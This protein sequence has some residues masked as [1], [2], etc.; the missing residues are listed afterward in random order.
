MR[1][2]LKILLLMT[3]YCFISGSGAYEMGAISVLSSVNEPLEAR[4][5]LSGEEVL[6]DG[7]VIVDMASK[8]D[9]MRHKVRRGYFVSDLK[10]SFEKD[11]LGEPTIRIQSSQPVM[12]RGMELLVM[13][14]TTQEK[15]LGKYRFVLPQVRAVNDPPIVAENR[16]PNERQKRQALAW[17]TDSVEQK[18][19]KRIVSVD[20]K[21]S[22]DRAHNSYTVL[23]GDSLSYIAMK[24]I[25]NYPQFRSWKALM[26]RIAEINSDAFPDRDINRLRVAT[27][28]KLPA[29]H[30]DIR[31]S[32]VAV[33]SLT[34]NSFVS[35]VDRHTTLSKAPEYTADPGSTKVL[36]SDKY[37]KQL[38]AKT[39]KGSQLSSHVMERWKKHKS[40][41]IISRSIVDH[42]FSYNTLAEMGLQET[43]AEIYMPQGVF[44]G[45]IL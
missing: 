10:A 11:L 6:D 38:Q 3:G 35:S 27:T 33:A 31:G 22:G 2:V 19:N 20:Q 15:K 40:E 8:I 25:P 28:L 45:S 24:L 36:K 1:T 43:N 44:S 34:D 23:A 17:S 9:F 41:L 26:D 29:V 37:K 16:M 30:N 21:G 18:Q 12:V 4:I 39:D 32:A 7:P 13:M 14:L 5:S 42:S